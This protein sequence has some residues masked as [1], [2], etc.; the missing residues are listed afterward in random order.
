MFRIFVSRN[1]DD[2]LFLLHFYGHETSQ[3]N[4]AIK[5]VIGLLCEILSW[6]EG[7]DRTRSMADNTL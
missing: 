6:T 1:C 4:K 2:E 3:Q 7:P 5:F